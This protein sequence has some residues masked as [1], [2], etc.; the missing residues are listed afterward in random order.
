[1]SECT[2]H[3]EKSRLLGGE[4]SNDADFL[5]KHQIRFVVFYH[6]GEYMGRALS[7]FGIG[8]WIFHSDCSFEWWLASSCG[9][10][11]IAR[12]CSFGHSDNSDL[13][14]LLQSK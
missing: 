11:S 7:S 2:I 12:F 3:Y 10:R 14:R 6:E 5:V 1:M 4:G 8:I 13:R 9:T